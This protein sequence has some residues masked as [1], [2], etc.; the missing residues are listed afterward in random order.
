[1]IHDVDWW[2]ISRLVASASFSC[3][4]QS[5]VDDRHPVEIA[6]WQCNE[7]TSSAR[8][9]SL[10]KTGLSCDHLVNVGPI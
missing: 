7:K 4:G 8:R 10:G 2:R 6:K 3:A 9:P 1:M 5:L